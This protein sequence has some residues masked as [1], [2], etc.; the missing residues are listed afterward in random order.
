[1]ENVSVLIVEDDKDLANNYVEI[2]NIMDNI[3][4]DAVSSASSAIEKINMNQYDIAIVDIMLSNSV[5]DRF[6]FN[7]IRELKRLNHKTFIAV[8]SA[9]DNIEVSVDA[10][11]MGVHKYLLKKRIKGS[12]DIINLVKEGIKY[13][14]KIIKDSIKETIKSFPSEIDEFIDSK[15]I[16]AFQE[17]LEDYITQITERNYKKASEIAEAIYKMCKQI[18][19]ALNPIDQRT[20]YQKVVALASYWKLNRDLY[21]TRKDIS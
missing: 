4:I 9:S 8:L 3:K 2:I 17:H 14:K 13:K 7:V 19:E 11:E 12:Q 16:N 15:L 5:E 10:F 20:T 21:A 18:S 1:M 6:G